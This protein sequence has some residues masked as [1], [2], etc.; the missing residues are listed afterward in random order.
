MTRG[1]MG[2]TAPGGL[3]PCPAAAQRPRIA[4]PSRSCCARC[5]GLQARQA[6]RQGGVGWVGSRG[7]RGGAEAGW[8]GVGWGGVKRQAGRQ[9][10]REA[11]RQGGRHR[12][13]QD[14]DRWLQGA[15]LRAAA[16]LPLPYAPPLRLYPAPLPSPCPAP[17]LPCPALPCH[18]RPG[19]RSGT[20]SGVGWVRR[21]S[22]SMPAK[23]GCPL[24][25]LRSPAPAG[26]GSGRAAPGRQQ[27]ITALEGAG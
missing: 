16:S 13:G 8:F 17:A 1:F 9:G 2:C 12:G 22:Q 19:S 27:S 20:N 23:K 5:P 25:S 24:S 7:R 15:R 11:R 21:A 3:L 6:P 14:R 26:S 4:T 10:G 18:H